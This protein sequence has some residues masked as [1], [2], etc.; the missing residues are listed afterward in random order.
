MRKLWI[1]WLKNSSNKNNVPKN[2]DFLWS[3]KKMIAETN[4]HHIKKNSSQKSWNAYH[5]TRAKLVR[6][7]LIF[8]YFSWKSFWSN[9]SQSF[10]NRWLFFHF[11]VEC[12]SLRIPIEWD[13]R[14]ENVCYLCSNPERECETRNEVNSM[15]ISIFMVIEFLMCS[16][17]V[18]FCDSRSNS[19]LICKKC[20]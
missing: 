13:F 17:S 10:K 19:I 12:R 1:A 8:T 18:E 16:F 14:L 4:E 3:G 7:Q 6:D 2:Y 9:D 5:V 11:S 20:T 15:E